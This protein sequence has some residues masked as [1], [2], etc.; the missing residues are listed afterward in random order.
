MSDSWELML[1]LSDIEEDD[2]ED[3]CQTFDDIAEK[4]GLEDMDGFE[5]LIHDLTELIDIGDSPLTGQ[6]YKGFAHNNLWLHKKEV[7]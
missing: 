4:Y 3:D 6:R 2:Y 1:F 5:L 7:L